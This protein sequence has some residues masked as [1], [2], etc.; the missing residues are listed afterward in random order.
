MRSVSFPPSAT[1]LDDV[2]RVL[3]VAAHPDDI[4]FGAAGTVALWTDSG[5]DVAYCLVT[6]GDAGGFDDTPRE[7]MP[8]L[9][10]KEQRA[11][12]AEVGVADVTFLDG[13]QDGQVYVTHDLRRDLTR[14]IRRLRP[15][16]MLVPAPIRR[17]DRVG[18]SHPDH[19]ATGEAA[20]SA[21]YPDSRNPFAHPEL[22][23]EEDLEPWTVREVWMMAGP[24]PDHMVDITD[25]FPRKL[26]ALRAHASQTSHLDNLDE[27]L[28]GWLGANAKAA[29]LGEGRLAE[30]FTVLRTS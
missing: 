18:P 26:A 11:A 14:E 30:A 2:E 21:V 1:P 27:M 23:A 7:Q 12:A 16:R 17:W 25:V 20:W 29:G 5:I 19:L 10:E 8:L 22:L 9:R 6:R 28:R 3:V 4:D 15:D 24:N 13:Y